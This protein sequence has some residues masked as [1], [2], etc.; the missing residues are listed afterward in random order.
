VASLTPERRRELLEAEVD[1]LTEAIKQRGYWVRG[2]RGQEILNPA[3]AARRAALEA[4]RK[5]DAS[6]PA[7]PEADPLQ[8]YLDRA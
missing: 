4:I 2:S 8:E 3:L 5:L 7:Q 6:S 1:E